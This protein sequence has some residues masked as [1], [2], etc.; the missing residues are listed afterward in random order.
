MYHLEFNITL[1]GQQDETRFRVTLAKSPIAKLIERVS[2]ADQNNLKLVQV[3]TSL[4]DGQGIAMFEWFGQLLQAGEIS[5]YW[6]WFWPNQEVTEDIALGDVVYYYKALSR[7]YDVGI[8]ID[9][10]QPGAPRILGA[11]NVVHSLSRSLEYT[12][13]WGKTKFDSLSHVRI[14]WIG[15]Q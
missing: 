12:M 7:T 9:L 4:P 6:G 11:G 10:P 1:T 13:V 8:V 14:E 5:A 2:T 3:I 15:Y